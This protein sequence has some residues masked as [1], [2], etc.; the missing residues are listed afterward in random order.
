MNLSKRFMAFAVF[1][2]IARAVNCAAFG[3]RQNQEADIHAIIKEWS[4]IEHSFIEKYFP[5]NK[6]IGGVKQNLILK[7]SMRLETRLQLS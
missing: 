3:S 2:F 1:S 6:K 5:G 4:S 7:K